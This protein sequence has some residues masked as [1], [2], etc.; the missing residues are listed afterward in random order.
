MTKETHD[1]NKK[2]FRPRRNAA[3]FASVKVSH[4]IENEPEVPR[5]GGGGESVKNIPKKWLISVENIS[6][7]SFVQ[8]STL[9]RTSVRLLLKE[10]NQSKPLGSV[11]IWLRHFVTLYSIKP[12]I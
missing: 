8:Q 9:F 1:V 3:A 12:C 6:E 4:Q 10:Q 11:R 2:L 5:G 7:I